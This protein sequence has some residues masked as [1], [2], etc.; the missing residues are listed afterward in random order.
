M[1]IIFITSDHH[2]WDFL[3]SIGG[4]VETPNLDRL[5]DRGVRL[6][7]AYCQTPLCVPCRISMTTG[8]YPM[9]TGYFT[10]RHPINPAEPTFVRQLQQ[11]GVHTAMIGKLHHH[12]H[13]MDADY[14]AHEADIHALGFNDVHETSGKQGSGAIACECRYVEFLRKEGLLEEYRKWTGRWGQEDT[15][16]HFCDPWPWDPSTTQDAYIGHQ[17]KSFL[18]RQPRDRPFYLHLGFVG[19]HPPFDAPETFRR[20]EDDAKTDHADGTPPVNPQ[21]WPA[22]L[23]CIREV[24]HHVGEVLATLRDLGMEEDTLIIYSSDHGDLAGEHGLWGKVYFYEGSVHVPFIAAGPG[25]PLGSTSD[26]L[27]ELIDVGS[28]FCEFFEVDTHHWDQGKSLLPLLRGEATTHRDS[29]FAEMGSDKMLFDGRYKLMYGDLS[30][31]TRSE[32]TRPP[33]NGPAFGRPVNLPP[34]QIALYDLQVDPKEQTNLASDPANAQLLSQMKE[35]LLQRII[36][37][38]QAAPEDSGSVL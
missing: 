3:S 32:F 5:A 1:N 38:F 37:N 9:N 33:Y 15:R 30:K 18:K 8:R 29:V 4:P 11:S 2:R 28:T 27:V 20:A 25:I 24:D 34:D 16:S 36:G 26:A 23:A 35:K 6:N 17:A 12:V 21:W 14:S 13:V 19:P 31:D 7:N 10:N 22:Y